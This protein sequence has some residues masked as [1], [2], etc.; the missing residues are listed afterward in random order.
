M[1]KTKLNQS[2]NQI[3][4]LN[5]RQKQILMG[6]LLGDGSLERR[7][8][9]HNARLRIDHTYLD[10]K[11]YVGYLYSEFHNLCGKTPKIIT[12]KSD[13][14]TGKI[15]R[16]IYFKTFNLFSLNQYHSLFYKTV[17]QGVMYAQVQQE[18]PSI[19][20]KYLKYTKVVPDDIEYFLT[21]LSL[22]HWLMGDGYYNSSDK[23]IILCTEGF[24]SLEIDKL[25]YA[26]IHKF[27]IKSSKI[28]RSS[29]FPDQRWRIKINLQDVNKFKLLV[30]DHVLPEMLY[31][32]GEHNSSVQ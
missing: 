16:S 11:A 21:P 17:D 3:L 9:S 5:E 31:K 6:L 1:K 29:S 30:I 19:E 22:A 10:Q 12:H 20:T 25:I 18:R 7:K 28:K 15:Y 13:K 2:K 14:R 27:N 26:L 32:L 23:R 24:T 8:L 4:P